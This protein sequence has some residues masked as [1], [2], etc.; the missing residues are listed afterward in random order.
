[1]VYNTEIAILANAL[2]SEPSQGY[3]FSK[4]SRSTKVLADTCVVADGPLIYYSSELVGMKAKVPKCYNLAIRESS[5][6][7][8]DAKLKLSEKIIP[9]IGEENQVFCDPINVPQLARKTSCGKA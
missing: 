6:R 2:K 5:G 3:S 4:N 9:F 7:K 8:Y 1:M